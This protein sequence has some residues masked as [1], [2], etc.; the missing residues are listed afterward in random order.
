M[1]KGPAVGDVAHQETLKLEERYVGYRVALAAA[2]LEL[3][4]QQD[5][6]AGEQVRRKSI[7]GRIND[8]AAKAMHGKGQS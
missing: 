3:L 6:S 2:L 4:K 8:L 1:A 7:D 5:S